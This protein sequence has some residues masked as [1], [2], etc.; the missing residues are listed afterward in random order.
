MADIR[1]ADVLAQTIPTTVEQ[2]MLA[3]TTPFNGAAPALST[4]PVG[5]RTFVP[6]VSTVDGIARMKN[7]GGVLGASDPG[8][9]DAGDAGGLFEF[10]NKQPIQVERIMADFGASV[11][12]TLTLVTSAG[13]LVLSTGTVRYLVLLTANTNVLPMLNPGEKLKLVAAGTAAQWAR[14]VVSLEQRH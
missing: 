14:V 12:Y 8:T 5:A 13:D 2:K 3:G 4:E 7:P 9:L 6:F 10:A 1:Q 11:A